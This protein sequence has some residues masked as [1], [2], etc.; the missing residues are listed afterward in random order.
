MTIAAMVKCA[1]IGGRDY[2]SPVGSL[3]LK[4][5]PENEGLVIHQCGGMENNEPHYGQHIAGT[6]DFSL[7]VCHI[8]WES[9]QSHVTVSVTGGGRAI[10]SAPTMYRPHPYLV[11]V[12]YSG[13]S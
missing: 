13:N 10:I 3:L 12:A 1:Y 8:H 2:Q 5:F 6:Q 9:H 4:H 7:L 11:Q